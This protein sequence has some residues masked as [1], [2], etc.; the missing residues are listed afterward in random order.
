MTQAR[1]LQH[2]SF[3]GDQKHGPDIAGSKIP[4][5][6]EVGESRWEEQTGSWRVG[7]AQTGLKRSKSGWDFEIWIDR[8]GEQTKGLA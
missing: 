7:K 4:A 1:L 2:H 8:D 5:A 6:L 3:P